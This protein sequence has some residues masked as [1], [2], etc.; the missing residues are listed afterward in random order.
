LAREPKPLRNRN[1]RASLFSRAGSHSLAEVNSGVRLYALGGKTFDLIEAISDLLKRIDQG[2]KTIRETQN[3]RD[4]FWRTCADRDRTWQLLQD[5]Q[6]K[7]VSLDEPAKSQAKAEFDLQASEHQKL[8]H[9]SNRQW[10]LFNETTA[11]IDPFSKAVLLLLERVPLQP[12]WDVYRQAVGCLDVGLCRS[13]TDPPADSALETLE[14][15]LREMRALAI[16]TQRRQ[17]RRFEPFPTP[18]GALWTDVSIIFISEHRVRIVVLGVTQPR[19]YAEMGFEDQ[20]G[21]GGKPDSAWGL[22]KV[23]AE[24]AGKIERPIDFKRPGW[25]KIEKQVQVVRAGLRELFGLPGDPLPFRKHSGYEAQF[26][27]KL[28]N[29]IEH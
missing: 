26:E 12:E 5:L 4:D 2:R 20:R 25:P 18:D 16:R 29:S 3:V 8:S 24:C 7:M 14:I 28:G 21:G 23:L 10:P 1:F 13:W 22:L 11:F 15:R 27:I 17:L 6:I 19:S 9:E